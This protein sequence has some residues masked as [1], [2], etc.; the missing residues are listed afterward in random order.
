MIE[1]IQ[2]EKLDCH[3]S[4]VVSQ[5]GIYSCPMLVND[6]RARLGST[7]NNCSKI[8]YLDCEK[9]SIC[10]KTNQKVQVNDWM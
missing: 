10:A 6:Y 5:N 2:I 9:C 1:N 8:N 4:R 3:N 7:L